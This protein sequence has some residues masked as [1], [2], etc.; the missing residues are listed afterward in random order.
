MIAA[1]VDHGAAFRQEL[2]A[3]PEKAQVGIHKDVGWGCLAFGVVADFSLKGE[4]SV[5]EAGKRRFE[6][7]R[8]SIHKRSLHRTGEPGPLVDRENRLLLLCGEPLLGRGLHRGIRVPLCHE[9]VEKAE[10]ECRVPLLGV[11]E[12]RCVE[13]AVPRTAILP[14]TEADDPIPLCRSD[15]WL[16]L[17]NL[18]EFGLG[19]GDELLSLSFLLLLRGTQAGVIL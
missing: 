10:R 2:P 8:Q 18:G 7:G 6:N 12:Q 16:G 1:L 14:P 19:L 4:D 5:S 11:H 3:R 15:A 13:A 17:W 9:N